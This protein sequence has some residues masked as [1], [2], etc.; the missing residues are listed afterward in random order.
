MKA[1]KYSDVI[2]V[3][4]KEYE[5]GITLDPSRVEAAIRTWVQNYSPAISGGLQIDLHM[6]L[7]EIRK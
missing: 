6:E 3:D 4:G 2:D 5:I 7:T 1:K